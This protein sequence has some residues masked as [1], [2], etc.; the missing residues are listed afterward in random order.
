M[1]LLPYE[2]WCEECNGEGRLE[3]V[4]G[5]IGWSDQCPECQ[6]SGT[7]MKTDEEMEAENVSMRSGTR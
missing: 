6:G 2:K 4:L 7:V 1:K 3:F 5:D